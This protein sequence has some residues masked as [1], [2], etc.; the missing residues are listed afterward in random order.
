MSRNTRSDCTPQTSALNCNRFKHGEAMSSTGAAPFAETGMHPVRGVSSPASLPGRTL[1]TKL[2]VFILRVHRHQEES[3]YST[4]VQLHVLLHARE[5]RVLPNRTNISRSLTCCLIRSLPFFFPFCCGNKASRIKH[6][7]CKRSCLNQTYF[8]CIHC[9]PPHLL[10]SR[11][12][13]RIKRFPTLERSSHV[14]VAAQ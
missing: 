5:K 10:N 2:T 7:R 11:D 3:A 6:A 13:I 8:G 9:A 14:H 4:H 1:L 12:V